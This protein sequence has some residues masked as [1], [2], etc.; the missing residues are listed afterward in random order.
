MAARYDAIVVGS[1]FG[2]GATA[3]RLAENGWRVCVLE[4]GRRFGPDDWPKDPGDAPRMFWHHKLNPRGFFDLRL[5]KDVAVLTAAGVGGGSLIYA[6]VQLRAPADVFEQPPWP[7]AIS[8]AALDPY[9]TRTEEAL[10]PQTT[11][12]DPALAK[13]AAFAA[14]GTRA[15]RSAERLPLSI[16][17]GHDRGHPFS[18]VRQQACANLGRCNIGCPRNAMNTVA[19]SYVARAEQHGAAVMPL[20][21]VVQIEPPTRPGGNW[22]VGFR[23][24]AAGGKDALE[25]PVVVLSAGTVG[26]PR[27]L[28]KNRR[29][30]PGLSEALG[31]RFSGNGDALGAA[32]DPSAPDV[33]GAH[34]DHGP[35]MTSRLDYTD[36]RHFMLADGGLPEGWT[37]LLKVARGL[38]AIEGWR[39]RL[40]QLKA[41]LT[42]DVNVTPR[43]VEPRLFGDPQPITDSLVFLMI[44]R[45]L[46]HGRMRLTPILRRFDIHWSKEDNAELF[47]G[48]RRATNE[49]ADG[50][51]ATAWFEP[52]GGPLGKFM[53]VHPLGGAPMADDP[54]DGVVDG[55]GKAHGYD[56]LYVADGSIVPTALGVN[57]SKT[58]AALAERSVEHL[59]AERGP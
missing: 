43:H 32:F 14:A 41:A 45:D 3:C 33:R 2:G 28:L 26:T 8:R 10:D 29:R 18:G 16:H 55:Y 23:D 39:R 42:S 59:I 56:G 25:A 40:L 36:D 51:Q 9:Y 17:F 4:R 13:V 27:L 5:T 12:E 35:V 1:G 48:M 7:A 22:R 30:L 46:A 15:G 6:N 38:S 11:P 47:A 57:P 19:I 52:D 24:L 58:I 44:G 49:V 53:T 31:S 54:A 20:R 50:A 34:T 21:E 37:G